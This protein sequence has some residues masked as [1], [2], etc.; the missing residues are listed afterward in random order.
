MLDI[1]IPVERE[2]KVGLA[3]AE[4]DDGRF[5]RQI[6]QAV[7]RDLEKAVDLTEFAAVPGN[8]LPVLR[9]YRRKRP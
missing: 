7:F 6:F 8:D 4:I 1:Q 3:A 5:F 9:L 2:S